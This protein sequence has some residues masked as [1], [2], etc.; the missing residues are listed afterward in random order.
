MRLAKVALL[1]TM[2][3]PAVVSPKVITPRSRPYNAD[4]V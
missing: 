1:H 3:V 2:R 4:A